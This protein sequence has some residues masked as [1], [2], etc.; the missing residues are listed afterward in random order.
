M[1]IGHYWYSSNEGI[2]IASFSP[3]KLGHFSTFFVSQSKGPKLFNGLRFNL[4][5]SPCVTDKWTNSPSN[6]TSLTEACGRYE[7]N[8]PHTLNIVFLYG[9]S[10]LIHAQC[11]SGCVKVFKITYE[12]F[13]EIRK[14]QIPIGEYGIRAIDNLILVQNY[15]LQETYIIDIMSAEYAEKPFCTFWNNMQETCP[16][17]SLKIKVFIQKPK[18]IAKPTF[19]YDK[20][21]IQ[22]LAMFKGSGSLGGEVIECVLPLDSQFVYTD[23]DI[24][25]DT[26]AGRCYKLQFSPL[27]VVENHPNRIECALF[28]FRRT[29]CKTQAYD[30]LKDCLRKSL[31]IREIS[32]FFQT[33]NLNYK[34]A[35]VEKKTTRKTVS[36]SDMYMRKLSTSLEPDLKIDEGMVV[37]FQSDMFS[38]LFQALFEENF[39]KHEYLSSIL[40]EY[41]HSLIDLD[42]DVQSSLQLLLARM[43]IKSGD[44]RSLQD[45]V[46]YS[47]FTDSYEMVNL[48]IQ[49]I[50]SYYMAMQLSVDMLF[51]MRYHEKLID[52]I[53]EKDFI[54][55]TLCLLYKVSY[56]RFD[57]RKL[58]GKCEEIGDEQ[59]TLVVTQFIKEKSLS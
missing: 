58:L 23:N 21:P 2:L 47:A 56:P 39:V 50:P 28:L 54:Y 49:L 16:V 35:I 13:E 6:V 53:L 51:R 19:L 1:N 22:D 38:V 33:I 15:T 5:L 52:I 24:C 36:K 26:K 29:G 10:Y 20:K 3:P 27:T 34:N 45:L 32:N 37:L 30:F 14:I 41:I 43:L 17:V 40:R 55:E 18:I 8:S 48:L 9:S 31:H 7:N 46:E 11:L 42:I 4:D 59:M 12:K 44:L 57:I 25:V